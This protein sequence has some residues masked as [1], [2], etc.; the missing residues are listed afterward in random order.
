MTM[1]CIQNVMLFKLYY[2]LRVKYIQYKEVYKI[3]LQGMTQNKSYNYYA[4][5]T[6]TSSSSFRS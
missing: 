4:Y 1:Q 5:N 2:Y 6:I 3:V